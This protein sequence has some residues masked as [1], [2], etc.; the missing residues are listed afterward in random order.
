MYRCKHVHLCYMDFWTP[1]KVT[2]PLQM[3]WQSS[4]MRRRSLSLFAVGANY[5]MNFKCPQ[6]YRS[7]ELSSTHFWGCISPSVRWHL[8]TWKLFIFMLWGTHIWSLSR[9]LRYTLYLSL[10]GKRHMMSVR[11]IEWDTPMKQNLS[12][13]GGDSEEN[14]AQC[15]Y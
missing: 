5:T 3:V 1:L 10:D 11:V 2:V 7:K 13:F 4:K 14:R 9:H 6:K 15:Y 12:M 8:V